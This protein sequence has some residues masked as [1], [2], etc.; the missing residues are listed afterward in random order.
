MEATF[1]PVG[2][3]VIFLGGFS[4]SY[5]IG[6]EDGLGYDEGHAVCARNGG[7]VGYAGGYC[8]HFGGGG[9]RGYAGGYSAHTYSQR[10]EGEG[11]GSG[12]GE[13]DPWLVGYGDGTITLNRRRAQKRENV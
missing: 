9:G 13:G 7:G 8:S 10:D 5:G 6:Y 1:R 11:F 12:G 4:S 2:R 3:G